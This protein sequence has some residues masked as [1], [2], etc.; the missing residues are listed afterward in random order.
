MLLIFALEELLL[1]V[2]QEHLMK[3]LVG[4]AL[5]AELQKWA[6]LLCQRCSSCGG[7]LSCWGLKDAL[8]WLTIL[9]LVRN[10]RF[11]G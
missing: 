11:L 9:K 1:A 7:L 10:G 6:S 8:A 2:A 5:L 4:S 3:R